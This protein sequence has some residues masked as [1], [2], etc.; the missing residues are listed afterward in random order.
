MKIPPLE[1][2]LPWCRLCCCLCFSVPEPKNPLLLLKQSGVGTGLGRVKR[3]YKRKN[4]GSP[5][6][7]GP[8]PIKRRQTANSPAKALPPAVKSR[9]LM[10]KENAPS[11]STSKPEAEVLTTFT[12]R[13]APALAGACDLTDIK[14]LLKEWVTTITGRSSLLQSCHQL[15]KNWCSCSFTIHLIIQYCILFFH[16][17]VSQQ[18]INFLLVHFGLLVDNQLDGALANI[19]WNTGWHDWGQRVLL[20]HILQCQ[21]KLPAFCF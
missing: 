18:F 11:T 17:P 2:G 21:K 8:S 20:P 3:R 19:G 16:D 4:A 1:C 12:P 6:K 15:L 9:E 14:T 5:A 7:K 10:A 13:P